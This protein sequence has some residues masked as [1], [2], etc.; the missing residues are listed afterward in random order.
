MDHIVIVICFYKNTMIHELV[1][2]HQME[3]VR[4]FQK[5]PNQAIVVKIKNK[6]ICQTIEI[7]LIKVEILDYN[8]HKDK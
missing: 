8:S 3:R 1:Q 5:N 6:K 4:A 7:W 2:K